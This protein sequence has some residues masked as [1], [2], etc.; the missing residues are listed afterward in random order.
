MVAMEAPPL[1]TSRFLR[2]GEEP[3]ALRRGFDAAQPF[4]HLVLDDVLDVDPAAV[5]A[6]FPTEEWAGWTRY[7][8][9]YQRRKLTCSDL[10]AMPPLLRELT[11]ELCEPIFLRF[12]E[13][14]TG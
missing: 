11:R 9:E 10:P 6:V 3:A 12:L 1:G 4:P 8:D 13:G 14:V 7:R 2:P 5:V